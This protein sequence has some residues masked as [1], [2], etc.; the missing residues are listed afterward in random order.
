MQVYCFGNAPPGGDFKEQMK[1]FLFDMSDG[2]NGLLREVRRP[3][4]LS[5]SDKPLLF[6][7]SVVPA[8]PK[9]WS[10]EVSKP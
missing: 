1:D 6:K 10:Y 4:C 9:V 5:D 7:G 2:M 8:D 3:D